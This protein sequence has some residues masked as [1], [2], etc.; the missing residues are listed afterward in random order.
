MAKGKGF[1][2]IEDAHELAQHNFHSSYWI[3]RVTSYT[4]ATW[5]AEKKL[6]LIILPF[7]II[8]WILVVLS[9]ISQTSNEASFWEILFDFRDSASTSR[10]VSFLFLIFYT[11]ITLVASLQTLFMK[12]PALNEQIVKKEPK[13]KYPKRRKDYGRN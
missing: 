13:K 5:M 4:Y 1:D 12:R 7:L 6:S 10:F 9:L 11:I 2:V 3:N 8:T